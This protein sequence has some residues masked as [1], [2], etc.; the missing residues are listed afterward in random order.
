M[1]LVD[2]NERLRSEREFDVVKLIESGNVS[3]LKNDGDL[4]QIIQQINDSLVVFKFIF[5]C[6]LMFVFHVDS[7][8]EITFKDQ[9]N[10]AL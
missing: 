6:K 5:D 10:N 2:L 7:S 1:D 8:G 9:V 4:K 3:L